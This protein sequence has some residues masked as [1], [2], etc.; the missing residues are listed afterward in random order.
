MEPSWSFAKTPIAARCKRP[1][2][3]TAAH[4]CTPH[5]SHQLRLN[6]RWT[7]LRNATTAGSLRVPNPW[8]VDHV[9]HVEPLSVAAFAAAIYH[10]K[11][12]ASLPMNGFVLD[13]GTN[14]GVYTLLASAIA[15]ELDLVGID[16]QPKCLEVTECGLRLLHDSAL[17]R[18]VHLLTRYVS[19]SADDVA[20]GVPDGECGVMVSPT[21]TRGRSPQGKLLGV[22]PH[23]RN[24]T[25]AVVERRVR[26]IALGRHLLDHFGSKRAA[27]VKVDTEGFETRVFESLRPAWHLLGD[28]VFELQPEAWAHHGV[29]QEDGLRTLRD[30]IRANRY[31]V[32]TLP[33]TALGVGRGEAWWSIPPDFVD[34]CRLPRVSAQ[35]AFPPNTE[36]W[37]GLG[38][39]TVMHGAHLEALIRRGKVRGFHEFLLTRKWELC[40]DE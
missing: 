34:P 2:Q 22:S 36:W 28:I 19:N 38:N 13:V 31:R 37:R 11:Q 14:A 20:I 9:S 24:T 40:K 1:Q 16:M 21:A 7:Q 12:R 26:P 33:H 3:W 27:V 4:C 29:R 8:Q 18:N 30:L 25:L 17:P 5:W 23:E 32:V 10:W 35:R 6:R 15:P 39:A